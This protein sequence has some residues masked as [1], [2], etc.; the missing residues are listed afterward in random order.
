MKSPK[1]I[2]NGQRYFLHSRFYQ[3]SGEGYTTLKFA[4]IARAVLIFSLFLRDC[5]CKRRENNCTSKRK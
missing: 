5:V 3:L 1:N 4:A 2:F